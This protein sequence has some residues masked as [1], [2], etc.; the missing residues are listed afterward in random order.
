MRS[1]KLAEKNLKLTDAESVL[2]E[3]EMVADLCWCGRWDLG[4]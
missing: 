2:P 3:G 4:G 1:E